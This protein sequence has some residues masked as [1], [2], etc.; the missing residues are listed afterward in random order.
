[1]S[2]TEPF[3]VS[4]EGDEPWVVLADGSKTGGAVSFG[5]AR[6]PRRTSGPSL[7]VHQREDE[8]AYVIEGIM[9]FQVGEE[10]F[11]A[12]PGTLV[13][14]PRSVPHTFANL[15]NESAWVFGT[16][17][18]AGLEGMFAEQAGYFASL[19]GAPDPAVVEEIG[20]RYGVAQVGPP[21]VPDPE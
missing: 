15:S 20:A 8:A 9:T 11:E 12:G 10:T 5:E 3:R 16:I 6:L 18:P 19:S 4:R 7:H 2:T 14:L 21:L 13:W 1:M 17:T